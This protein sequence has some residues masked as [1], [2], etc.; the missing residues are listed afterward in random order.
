MLLTLDLATLTGFCHGAGDTGELPTIG[1]FRLPATG[2]DVGR[3]LAAY[4]DWLTEKVSEVEPELVVMEAPILHSQTTITVTRKLQGLAG[5]T[6]MV[7]TDLNRKYRDLGL[8]EIEV[9]EVATT[10]VKKALTGNGRAEKDDMIRAARH[11][12]L[13]PACSDEADAFGVWLLTVRKRFPQA[14]GHW[15]PMN[16]GR[17]A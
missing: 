14:A 9:A 2:A 15:D 7:I 16:F 1:S 8:V 13:N 5:V 11:Y 10:S 12:G 3:F 4:R 17:A 6:E